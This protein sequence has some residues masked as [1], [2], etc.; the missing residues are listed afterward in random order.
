MIKHKIVK[1]INYKER[2]CVII[3]LDRSP[4]Q[5]PFHNGYVE[6]KNSE[7]KKHYDDYNIECEEL[8]Y[9]GN[10]D[11]G[12]ELNAADGKTYIGFDTVHGWNDNHPESKSIES[13]EKVCK[14]IVDELTKRERAEK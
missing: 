2:R 13:V 1:M 8:T 12:K 6:L 10:L 4:Y 3:L 7:V 9:Q 14:K 11:F 5:K